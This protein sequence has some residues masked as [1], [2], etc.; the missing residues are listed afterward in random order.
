[1]Q[2]IRRKT[3]YQNKAR[4]RPSPDRN[5]FATPDSV[6]YNYSN[7]TRIKAYSYEYSDSG[8]LEKFTDHINGKVTTY[9]YDLNGRFVSYTETKSSVSNY[10]NQYSV[11]Y[12][13]QGIRTS[14]TV[15]GVTTTYYVNGG[16]I[17]RCSKKM[18]G[19]K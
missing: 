9:N 15:N 7:G 1:M 10:K 18:L 16:R 5:T 4:A 13:D 6:W 11:D 8:S 2:K 17:D 14:K 3:W 19:I 12:D